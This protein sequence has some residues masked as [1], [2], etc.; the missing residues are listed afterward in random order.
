M[1]HPCIRVAAAAALAVSPCLANL[2]LHDG[3]E[4]F[5]PSF[6]GVD[7]PGTFGAPVEMK[8]TDEG[9][10]FIADKPGRVYVYVDG[11]LQDDP[12]LD[13]RDIVN[14]PGDRGLLS[15]ALDPE[16]EPDGSADSWLYV[17]YTASPEFGEELIFNEDDKY[18]WGV[19]ARYPVL[20][21][22][23]GRWLADEAG[24]ET[25]LGERLP[26]GSAPT[27]FASLHSSHSQCSVMFGS[28]G[29]LLLSH[30][31]GAHFNFV[32]TGGQDAPGF[33]D[34]IHPVTGL[35]GPIPRDQ[36]SG[37]MR[38]QDL[39]SLAGKVI[40]IDPDTAE[41]LPSNPFWDGDPNSNASRV[42]ALGFRN[43]FRMTLVPDTGSDDPRD[44]D[45]GT[46]LIGDVGW[47]SS[48]ELNWIDAPG[49][50][51]GWPCREGVMPMLE[52]DPV[53]APDPNPFNF[54][55]CATANVG[56]ARDPLLSY[57]HTD[58]LL[59]FPAGLWLDEN[60]NP[61]GG[62]LGECVMA[63]P[64]YTGT[65]Y[66]EEFHGVFFYGDFANDYI[67]T[68]ELDGSNRPVAV[69]DFA[70][71]VDR[72]VDLKVHPITGELHYLT[73]AQQWGTGHVTRVRYGQNL[74]PAA[75][76]LV[77]V[78]SGA[79]PLTV[80]FD[81]S[82]STDPEAGTL[83]YRWDFGDGTAPFTTTTPRVT[84]VYTDSGI[85]NAELRVL[86]SEGL[87]D[88]AT[89]TI[90]VDTDPPVAAI[91]SPPSG[92][93]IDPYADEIEIEGSSSDPAGG[94]IDIEWRMDL[95]H[96]V[97]VHPDTYVLDQADENEPEFDLPLD[98]HG[99]GPEVIF[100]EVR[101]KASKADGSEVTDRAW[102][103]PSDQ[104][105]N[106]VGTGNL[107]SRLDELVPPQSQG[108]GNPDIEVIRDGVHPLAGSA[109]GDY[110]DT[111]HGGD[112][113][114]DD[115]IGVMLPGRPEP[116]A[117][118][119]SLT[120]VEGPHFAD[121][122]WFDTIDV[123]IY[124]GGRWSP[125]E[126][127]RISPPYPAGSPG[128]GY[129]RFEFHFVPRYGEGI[130]VRGVPGGS[131]K[132]IT[133]SELSARLL[134][135]EALSTDYRDVSFEGALQ[136]KVDY[137]TPSGSLG[138]GNPDLELLR[139]GT[140][141]AVG[142]TSE[143]A[144]YAT[145]HN[146]DQGPE[147][148][149]GYRFDEP[150]T[151]E[152]LLFQEGLHFPTGGWFESLRVQGRFTTSGAWE[153]ITP[154]SVDP[155]F[156]PGPNGGL[157]YETFTFQIEPQ[158]LRDVRLLGVPGGSDQFVTAAELKVMGPWFDENSC[159]TTVYGDLALFGVA[160]ETRCSTPPLLG[161][162]LVVEVNDVDEP[163]PAAG[164]MMIGLAP[165]DLNLG[166]ATILVDPAGASFAPVTFDANG[167]ADWF[168]DIPDQATFAG[169]SLYIQAG[170]FD[171]DHPGG[172]RYSQGLQVKVC[173]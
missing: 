130:R 98:P 112:Q 167:E 32:D 12:V 156:L 173:Q 62:L 37:A 19:L 59:T 157:A 159:G 170:R 140:M 55:D 85:F 81:G 93:L 104:I 11:V 80:N 131:G 23:D 152:R 7:L 20:E 101:M 17:Y 139:N 21:Q 129:E 43:P 83:S 84:H 108:L 67:K 168:A 78:S 143:W 132:Y 53:P 102:Y 134:T 153:E 137:L 27:A 2:P 15:I 8:F 56:I 151:I 26:D 121:G 111:Y 128:A 54:L 169:I 58:S 60:D 142:S 165:A 103:Y 48:E 88:T 3:T 25:L 52:Y 47:Y 118:F 138:F 124:T 94:Q 95:H 22:P 86:D 39:R 66:P 141:P 155:Q 24:R 114:D 90:A 136:S 123:E 120:F 76:L 63:G 127:L 164:A 117:R 144:Q 161:Y 44:G 72:M 40:R 172:V 162:P 41:G 91:V 160:M 158:V 115:W 171:I 61:L 68:I 65:S 13:I 70:S 14:V 35:R 166:F 46:V 5:L 31:D 135:V 163:E 96:N 38:S 100:Y 4:S 50:N 49:L 6:E 73:L 10:L 57:H 33:D 105:L 69:R 107:I 116:Y 154:T 42:W 34:W 119:T 75:V 113:G 109:V 51:F 36:D 146:G 149:L 89:V 110:F 87:F 16:F 82:A 106:P 45:P 145:F 147:D 133:C 74:S 122:G 28:D 148:W 97:H 1:T 126:E 30:G 125:V 92:S 150:Q 71:N 29:T 18:S 99:S 79:S 77:D 64:K 9:H